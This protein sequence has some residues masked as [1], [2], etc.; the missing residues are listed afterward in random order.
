M[1]LLIIMRMI[2]ILK[3]NRRKHMG[4]LQVYLK[5]SKCKVLKKSQW[6]PLKQKK[7]VNKFQS[8]LFFFFTPSI[9]GKNLENMNVPE[10]PLFVTTFS[11]REL[12]RESMEVPPT[13]AVIQYIM[14]A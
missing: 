1:L 9:V 10:A 2:A 4:I 13:F 8:V 14:K 6:A 12:N 3:T 7:N 5:Y 11:F